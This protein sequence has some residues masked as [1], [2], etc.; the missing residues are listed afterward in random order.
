[1]LKN[2]QSLSV[3][4]KFYATLL[5]AFQWYLKSEEDEAFQQFIDK[6]NRVPFTSEAAEKGTRFN[7]LV[8]DVKNGAVAL[9]DTVGRYFSG[10]P[11]KGT[12]PPIQVNEK[13]LVK[14]GGF[15][16]KFS[17]VK[18]FVERLGRAHDQVYTEGVLP[19]SR[20]GVLLYGYIDEVQ[21]GGHMEDIKTT[22]NYTFPKYLHNWQ[23]IVYPYCMNA[24]G[25]PANYFSYAVTD[26]SNYYQ[27][28][29]VFEEKRD[30][31]RLVTICEQLIDFIEQHRDK[32]TDRKLFASEEIQT[33]NPLPF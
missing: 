31:A 11:L 28:D 29:Y 22:S 18:Q 9:V 12:Y 14:Y 20:G 33:V 24:N 4:Y 8:D 5:D 30:T 32:I 17:I 16:Y 25:I 3:K 15:E 1:M 19:T 10:G 6:L 7:E 2:N 13:G 23:H 27:E 21:P 26:F